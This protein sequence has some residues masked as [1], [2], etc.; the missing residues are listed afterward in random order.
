MEGVFLVPAA[1]IRA[2]GWPQAKVQ[3]VQQTGLVYQPIYDA[4][5]VDE[6]ETSLMQRWWAGLLL[7]QWDGNGVVIGILEW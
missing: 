2:N 3:Q 5:L 6:G 7:I 1:S 4:D